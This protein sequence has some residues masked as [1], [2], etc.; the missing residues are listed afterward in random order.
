MAN[1]DPIPFDNDKPA[2]P[3]CGSYRD[4]IE[5]EAE[6]ERTFRRRNPR[7]SEPVHRYPGEEADMGITGA[8][9]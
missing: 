8:E 7:F 9:G 2:D 3:A 5:H 6:A 4:Y 1:E